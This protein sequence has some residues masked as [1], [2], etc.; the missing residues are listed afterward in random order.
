VIVRIATEG[1]YEVPDTLYDE[2]NELDNRAVEA[3]DASDEE[4]FYDSY[5]ALIELV[6]ERGTRLGPEELRESAIVLPP[7]D[8]SLEEAEEGE[9]FTGDGLLPD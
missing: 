7:P 2:L 5:R 3:V 4:L 6:R 9:H 1:Q 8:L